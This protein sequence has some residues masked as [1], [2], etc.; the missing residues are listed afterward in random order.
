[1][2]VGTMNP[3]EGDLR[4]QLLDR[5]GLAVEVDGAL[6]G[7]ERREVVRRRIGYEA[8]P[9]GFMARWQEAERQ[10]RDRLLRSQKLL[11][12][13][14]VGDDILGLITDICAEYQVDG[15]RGDIVMYK[16]AGTIAAYE[17]R[18]QVTAEDVREAAQMALLHRQRRQPFQQ[19]HLV[20]EQLDQMI[21]EFQS[22][23]H[24][25]EPQDSSSQNDQGDDDP[26]DLDNN[27]SPP[28]EPEQPHPSQ[29]DGPQDQWFETGDAFSVRAL[30]LQPPDQRARRASG[31]RAKTVSGTSAG[32]YVGAKVPQGSVTDLAPARTRAARLRRFDNPCDRLS[33]SEKNRTDDPNVEA[34]QLKSWKTQATRRDQRALKGT[35]AQERRFASANQAVKGDD[36]NVS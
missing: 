20:T 3:E 11:P 33:P 14:Q 35:K 8:D 7:E 29:K 21:D 24:E 30:Q 12:Q 31:R 25:R 6:A 4:P 18:T 28:D 22:R 1:M 16:T 9:F 27:D 17:G 5:F 15:L 32:R 10:E 36:A 13:V 34:G 2:L 26:S 19:P 23:S